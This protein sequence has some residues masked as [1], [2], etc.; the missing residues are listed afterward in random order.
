MSGLRDSKAAPGEL[1]EV[2]RNHT[3]FTSLSFVVNSSSW[4]YLELYVLF[5]AFFF[6]S[7][8]AQKPFLRV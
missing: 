7:R 5:R 6:P 4:R 1:N 8:S 3:G 2:T